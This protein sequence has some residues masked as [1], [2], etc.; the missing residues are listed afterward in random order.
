MRVFH[1][2]LFVRR[3]AGR[4]AAGVVDVESRGL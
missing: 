1:A 4:R 3:A 2:R